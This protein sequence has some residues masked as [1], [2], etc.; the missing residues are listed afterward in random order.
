MN[1]SFNSGLLTG[2]LVLGTIGGAHATTY[3]F[4]DSD[5]L[6]G[7]SWGTMT[8]DVVDADTLSVRYDASKAIPS[9]SQATG[10]AFGVAYPNGVSFSSMTNP[11]SGVFGWDNDDLNW[12]LYSK[13]MNT[14]PTPANANEFT[15]EYFTFAATE[16]NSNGF[17]PPGIKPGTSDIFYINFSGT[18]DLS[19]IKW[20]G[21]RLQDLPNSVNG[22]SL[23]L[24]GGSGPVPVPEPT[25]MLLLG[26]GLAGLAAIG[27]RRRNV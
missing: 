10:F 16:G 2:L 26:T 25:T 27:R 11:T 19:A 20:T 17:N 12:I 6:S 9:T 8:I 3:T 15:G 23:F 22:G 1:K 14:L 7:I 24:I 18:I 5:I 13:N 21:V 4:S